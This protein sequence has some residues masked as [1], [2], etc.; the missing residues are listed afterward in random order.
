MVIRNVRNWWIKARTSSG[1]KTIGFGP[2]GSQGGF[3]MEVR[4]RFEGGT[5]TAIEVIGAVME[6]G[7]LE[8][9]VHNVADGDDATHDMV[10][11]SER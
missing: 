5:S 3:F 4:Q 9:R 1:S 8:L 10:I 11:R 2:S 7:M 6:D